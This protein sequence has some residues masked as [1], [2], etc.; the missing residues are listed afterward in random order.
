MAFLCN[1]IVY[2]LLYTFTI[3]YAK[4]TNNGSTHEIF[5]GENLVNNALIHVFESDKVKIKLKTIYEKSIHA[6]PDFEHSRIRRRC[7][8]YFLW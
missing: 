4:N 8:D 2:F 5:V 7:T 3:A 6:K 1:V